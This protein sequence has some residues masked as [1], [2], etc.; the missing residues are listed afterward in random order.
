MIPLPPTRLTLS[1]EDIAEY[2]AAK[3]GWEKSSKPE[4]RKPVIDNKAMR[5][6]E[7]EGRIGI[8]QTTK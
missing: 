2:E 3:Q 6:K 8:V 1:A 4:A 5:K 7:V